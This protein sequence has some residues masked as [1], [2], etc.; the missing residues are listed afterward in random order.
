MTI[1]PYN[2]EHNK[3]EQVESMFDSIAPKYDFLN[4]FFS[5]GIDKLWRKKVVRI[6]KSER[7][8]KILD[9]ATGT[10]DLAICAAKRIDAEITGIDL[11]EKMLDFGKEKIKR[12]HIENRIV[13]NKGDAEYINE[14]DN[15]FDSVMVAFG[16]R[17]FENVEKGLKEIL[18][19]LKPGGIFVILEF[20]K[21]RTFPVKNLYNFYFKNVV[22]FVGKV[23]SKDNRAY[24]YLPESV[25]AFPEGEQ[26]KSL[27]ES[28]G[29]N[30]VHIKP[31]TFRIATIYVSKKPEI[32]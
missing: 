21:P 11:S 6:I 10:G 29:Y 5:L 14:A 18:R 13:L 28:C 2:N 9:V 8:K 4:H 20:S 23:F 32:G 30:S 25:L 3:K 7:P 12:L 17:N 26:M 24:T 15:S 27:L 31:V 16:V 1:T 22:P 19:V